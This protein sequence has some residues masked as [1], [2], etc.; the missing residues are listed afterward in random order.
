MPNLD[1]IPC[2]FFSSGGDWWLFHRALATKF[3]QDRWIATGCHG[4]RE[5]AADA[6]GYG[7]VVIR[8]SSFEEARKIAES[9]PMHTTGVRDFQLFRW[10]INEGFTT[11]ELRFSDQ[12]FVIK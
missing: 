10:N 2:A 12:S 5:S 7:L 11:I 4:A 9:D 8:A 6:G 1:G 3:S